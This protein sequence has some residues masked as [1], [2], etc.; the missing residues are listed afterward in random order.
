M[1]EERGRVERERD[2]FRHFDAPDVRAVYRENHAKQTVDFVMSKREQYLPL[3]HGR[4][5]VWEVFERLDEIRDASD[6]D[7]ELSQRDHAIQTAE[8]LRRDGAPRWL[9]LTGLVH[10][11]G[12]ALC[13]FGEPQWAVV[14]DT[15]PVGCQHADAVV[16]AE[17]FDANPDR[18]DARYASECGIYR[19][20]CGLDA[21]IMS[22]GHDEYLYQVLGR[23]LPERARWII[24]FHSFYALHDAGAYRHLLAAG[25][26][27]KIAA[28]QEF[29]RYDLYSKADAAP[30]F[31]N[32]RGYYEHLVAELLPR[33]LDW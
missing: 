33:Q 1:S 15:F 19:A 21:L 3:R 14:G 26:E 12:K 23:F 5:G 6:P 32:V 28:L 4:M 16:L 9:V 2:D 27:P 17:L 20:G 10:D 25:D 11:L 29:R 22:W 13:L 7:T 8:R 24:R 18:R 30:A 31:E